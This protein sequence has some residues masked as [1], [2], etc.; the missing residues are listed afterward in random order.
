LSPLPADTF[1]FANAVN[2][3]G[4]V[5]GQSGTQDASGNFV[6]HAVLWNAGTTTPTPTDLGAS[7]GITSSIA[8]GINDSGVAVGVSGGAVEWALA[9]TATTTATTPITPLGLLSGA[10]D[11]VARAINANGQ[12][13]GY[14]DT[15][16]ASGNLVTRAVRWDAGTTTPTDLGASSTSS[17]AYGINANGVGVGAAAG[18]GAVEWAPGTTTPTALGRLPGSTSSGANAINASGQVVGEAGMQDASGNRVSHA[19]RWD[20]AASPPADLG[21]LSGITGTLSAITSTIAL[22]INAGGQVVGSAGTPLP[23]GNIFGHAVLW[24]AGATTPT[25][26]GDL[27]PPGSGWVLEGASAINDAVPVQIVGFGIINGAVHGFRLT[28]S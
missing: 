24:N 3:S 17:I 7:P 1:S 23:N 8:Y 18:S 14:A 12:V 9:A 21:T 5:V 10:T 28:C 19:V 27:L 2:A 4:Q 11:S 20:A 25:D 6:H 26:L 13:V 22:G 15:K 16:D